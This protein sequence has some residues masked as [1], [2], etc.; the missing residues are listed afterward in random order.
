MTLAITRTSRTFGGRIEVSGAKNLVL[1]LALSSLLIPGRTTLQRVPV[2]ILDLEAVINI[3]ECFGVVCT[4]EGEILHFENNGVTFNDIPRQLFASTRYA[5]LLL[6]I[7]LS[8]FSQ[9]RIFPTG[10]CN[11]GLRPLDIHVAG[12]RQFDY[13]VNVNSEG[14]L[15]ARGGGDSSGTYALPFPSVGATL[16]LLFAS[17]LGSHIRE[18]RN[19][20]EEPE[21]TEV[22][23][24]LRLCGADISRPAPGVYR[25]RGVSALTGGVWKLIPDRIEVG[26]Y[27][28]LAC[29]LGGNLQ[30]APVIFE[31]VSALLQL[32]DQ[33]GVRYVCEDRT[34]TLT[35]WGSEFDRRRRIDSIV[36]VNAAPYPGLP[37]D[38]QP[39][40]ASLAVGTARYWRIEDHVFPARSAHVNELRKLGANIR[41]TRG[42]VEIRPLSTP[43]AAAANLKCHDLRS[44][45]ASVFGALQAC[46]TSF[47]TGEE[48]IERGYSRFFEQLQHL[49]LEVCV[50]K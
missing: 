28:V 49:G 30:I 12:L 38:L 7:Q 29:I 6:G 2:G 5:S 35:I 32:L 43:L 16:N 37:S 21:V 19:A 4:R 20:A 26:T 25:I 44:G 50:S 17:V 22:V 46:G 45:I 27:A 18:I 42:G 23:A 15:D 9:S 3:V 1:P 10:G 8:L 24:Y 14:T 34:S 13:Q 33:L 36:H 31:H 11:L 39:I 41:V 40:I 48:Q 47:V